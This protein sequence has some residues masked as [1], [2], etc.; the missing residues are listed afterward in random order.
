MRRMEPEA[1]LADLHRLLD[2]VIE[3]A[4]KQLSDEELD[5]DE[6]AWAKSM[7]HSARIL[8]TLFRTNGNP[9]L[10]LTDPKMVLDA[11]WLGFD[12]AREHWSQDRLRELQRERGRK[13]GQ[14][15]AAPGDERRN[16]LADFARTQPLHIRRNNAELE[17]RWRKKWGQKAGGSPRTIQADFAALRKD[18]LI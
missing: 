7:R 1:L 2:V 6:K 16:R 12:A 3:M 4:D 5:D 13:S 17:R 11:F 9:R 18:G 15:R 8:Q 14:R 10:S